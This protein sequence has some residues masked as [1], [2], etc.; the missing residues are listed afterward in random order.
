[1]EERDKLARQKSFM[2]Y[3]GMSPECREEMNDFLAKQNDWYIFCKNCNEKI[4]GSIN[5][6]KNHG[7]SCK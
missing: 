3:S 6:V 5:T 4:I 7:K 2:Q 1:M